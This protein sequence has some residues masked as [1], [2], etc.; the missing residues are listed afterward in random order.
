M[1][2]VIKRERATLDISGPM[3]FV[4]Q[5]DTNCGSD[6]PDWEDN[7][8]PKELVPTLDEAADLRKRGWIARVVPME[9]GAA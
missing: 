9:G 7:S 5:I 4:V 6:E 2:A 3:L 8:H 1:P